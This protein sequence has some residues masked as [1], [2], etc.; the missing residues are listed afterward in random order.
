MK[1]YHGKGSSHPHFS[2]NVQNSMYNDI[3]SNIANQI[4]E[5]L[6]GVDIYPKFNLDHGHCK[7]TFS[8][9]ELQNSLGK[10]D[11]SPGSDNIAYYVK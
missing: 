5:R 6:T 7:T 10:K 2:V 8:F 3:D 4:L 9:M 11:T 1:Q